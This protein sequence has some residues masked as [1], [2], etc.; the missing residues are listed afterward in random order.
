MNICDAWLLY[1]NDMVIICWLFDNS[2]S[3]KVIIEVYKRQIKTTAVFLRQVQQVLLRAR[4]TKEATN[5]QSDVR[6]HGA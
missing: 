2:C 3:H 1:C 5:S 4:A 6:V